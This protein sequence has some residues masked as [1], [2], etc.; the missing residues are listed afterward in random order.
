MAQRQQKG[1]DMSVST[2][3]E[4]EGKVEEPQ[5]PAIAVARTGYRVSISQG[6]LEISAR[7]S[8]PDELQF[9]IKILQANAAIM[10]EASEKDAA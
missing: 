7:L 2:A 1:A 3:S 8:N 10:V 5:A 9:F 6:A 4:S